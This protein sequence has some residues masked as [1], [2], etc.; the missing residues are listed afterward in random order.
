M[1]S[2]AAYAA[3][4]Q[5]VFSRSTPRSLGRAINPKSMSLIFCLFGSWIGS[6][7]GGPNQID[8]AQ[9]SHSSFRRE[10]MAKKRE[11]DFEEDRSGNTTEDGKD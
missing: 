10:F 3:E 1:S 11:E 9:F 8:V 6:E 4:P 7:L 2:G 5:Q